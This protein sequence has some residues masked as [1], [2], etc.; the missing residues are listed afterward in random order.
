[1]RSVLGLV[2]R[3]ANA[4]SRAVQGAGGARLRPV[5][6]DILL[7]IITHSVTPLFRQSTPPPRLPARP[8]P[9]QQASPESQ[10]P[11]RNRRRTA[12]VNTPVS[13]YETCDVRDLNDLSLD[14]S[15]AGPCSGSRPT[16]STCVSPTVSIRD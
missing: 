11:P 9:E 13:T 7:D 16:S 10:S 6:H 1:M 8:R 5:C 14:T 15:C 4:G 2:V 3:A 12:E